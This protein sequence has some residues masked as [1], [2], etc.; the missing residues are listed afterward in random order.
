MAINIFGK[1][2]KP[3]IHFKDL[4]WG[5]A[6]RNITSRE[7]VLLSSGCEF[8]IVLSDEMLGAFTQGY[9]EDPYFEEVDLNVEVL[10]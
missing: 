5:H 10:A 6:Y 2:P 7:I 3:S 4:K 1:P 8:P 9:F